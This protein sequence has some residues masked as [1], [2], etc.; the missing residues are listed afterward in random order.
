MLSVGV[1]PRLWQRQ[2]SWGRGSSVSSF[3]AS[4]APW[5]LGT[6]LLPRS[7]VGDDELNRL[8]GVPELSSFITAPGA[9]QELNLG[10]HAHW[11]TRWAA[12]AP[13]P[14]SPSLRPAPPPRAICFFPSLDEPFSIGDQNETELVS[15]V[16]QV[17]EKLAN[18]IDT[19]LLRLPSLYLVACLA[20]ILLLTC[21]S[22]TVASL[23]TGRA[24]SR[25][26]R[27][28]ANLSHH[29]TSMPTSANRNWLK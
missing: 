12:P 16:G 18:E 5:P 7:V 23:N 13:A 24:M 17:D 19:D 6:A 21:F 28:G 29:F 2:R 20:T 9:S 26:K 14:A 25:K 11:Y 3:S 15:L 8:D 10:N 27:H 22:L 4:K 1:R